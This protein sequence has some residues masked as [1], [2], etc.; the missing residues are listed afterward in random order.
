MCADAVRSADGCL[1]RD[2]PLQALRRLD[3]AHATCHC[4][5]FTEWDEPPEHAMARTAAGR[6]DE[7]PLASFEARCQAPPARDPPRATNMGPPLSHA[8]TAFLASVVRTSCPTGRQGSAEE[9]PERHVERQYGWGRVH[10][11]GPG[12]HIRVPIMRKTSGVWGLAPR[13][14]RSRGFC[15]FR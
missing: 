7:A 1:D 15:R 14:H 11:G 13:D 12:S 10:C 8:P 6:L 2:E 4:E 9:Q 3:E 5:R